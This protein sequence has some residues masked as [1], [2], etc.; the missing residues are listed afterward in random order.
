MRSY[1]PSRRNRP[2]SLFLATVFFIAALV[3]VGC[4]D[5][6]ISGTEAGSESTEVTP[7]EIAEKLPEGADRSDVQVTN[8]EDLNVYDGGET[9]SESSLSWEEPSGQDVQPGEDGCK[10]VQIGFPFE[11]Y[12]ESYKRIWVNANGNLTLDG[13]NEDWSHP[14]V[15]DEDRS[16]IAPLYGDFSPSTHGGVYVDT[17]GTAPDRTFTVTWSEVPE[18]KG[19]SGPN[20]FQVR[21]FE[22]DGSI[23]FGYKELSTDGY[24]WAYLSPSTDPKMDV[25]ISSGEEAFI[26]S[27]SGSEIPALDSTN[28]C[29][30]PDG[31]GGYTEKA[32]S[33]EEP[34][35]PPVAEAGPDQTLECTGDLTSVSLDGSESSDPD[36]D[37]LSYSWSLG[38][39]ELSTDES[40]TVDLGYGTHAITLTVTDS[41]GASDTDEVT[42]EVADTTP[43]ELDYS[44]ETTRLWPPNHEMREAVTGISASDVCDSAPSVAVEVTSNEAINGEGDGDT[45]PDWQVVE[46][47]DG[48]LDVLLRAER[49]GQGDGRT[50]TVTMTAEDHAGNTTEETVEVTVPHDANG[51]GPQ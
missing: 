50:Y 36:G 18:F 11:F 32:G 38:D 17:S 7:E 14:D 12:G 45:A 29:Y 48:T 51:S 19:S 28:I 25:G 15:P 44:T 26:N 42:V 3:T 30:E 5:S 21:F 10:K 9:Q 1:Y 37:E 33:C 20:S 4:Q 16:L 6:S 47:E 22:E 35:E 41:E 31:D 27:A 24:N 43:P 8:E 34:N 39:T 46:N 40:P 13:C 49:S 23:Q 2:I